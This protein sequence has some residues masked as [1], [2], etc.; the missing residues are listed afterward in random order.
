MLKTIPY[1]WNHKL[2]ITMKKTLIALCMLF[3]ATF[4]VQAQEDQAEKQ[5]LAMELMK[6]DLKMDIDTDLLQ[7]MSTNMYFSE[8]PQVMVMGMVV[9][10]TYENAKNEL[11]KNLPPDFKVSDKGEKMMNGVKVIFLEGTSETPQGTIDCVVY[12]MKRDPET[13]TMFMGMSGTGTAQKY[14]DAIEKAANSVIK[15]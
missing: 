11:E 12:C 15:K 5:A 3:V 1:F 6:I 8:N 9:P 7:K 4:T 13:C 14:L 2:N 10:S